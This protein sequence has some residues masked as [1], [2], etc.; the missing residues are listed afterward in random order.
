MAAV[1]S[2][3]VKVQIPAIYLWKGKY[4]LQVLAVT[5]RLRKPEIVIYKMH[6]A[7]CQGTIQYFKRILRKTKFIIHTIS[8]IY[9]YSIGNLENKNNFYYKQNHIL[10]QKVIFSEA[11][12]NN[13]NTQMIRHTLYKKKMHYNGY[14]Y[15]FLIR[16]V[17]SI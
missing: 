11:Q 4:N 16:Y 15:K 10:F 1:K 3:N 2:I 7:I 5:R 17:N 14:A 6:I 13:R 9:K 12:S 8:F